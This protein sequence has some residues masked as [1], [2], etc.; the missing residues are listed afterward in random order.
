[1]PRW[2]CW[3]PRRELRPGTKHSYSSMGMSIL[4]P[5][6]VPARRVT[7]G[8]STAPDL[9]EFASALEA[10]RLVG[11]AYTRSVYRDRAVVGVILCDYDLDTQ[12]VI[13]QERDA[14]LG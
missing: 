5:V 4:A 11:H 13:S 1:V 7:S 6:H 9:V 8:F 2:E 14:V 12:P 3:L 10:D